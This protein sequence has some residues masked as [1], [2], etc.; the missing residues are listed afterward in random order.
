MAFGFLGDIVENIGEVLLPRGTRGATIGGAV[1][2]AIG[3]PGGAALGSSLGAATT[4]AISSG[5]RG[6]E[7]V[8]SP[9][10]ATAPALAPESQMSGARSTAM[11]PSFAQ[12]EG[13]VPITAGL[14]PAIAAGTKILRRPDVAATIGAVGGSVLDVTY[15]NLFGDACATKM[16][17]LVGMTKDGC[18][19]VTR[20]QQRVVILWDRL[21]IL[22][23][24]LFSTHG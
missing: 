9:T 2:G 17:K 18:P 13:R 16:P 3:G 1:G 19:T 24:I 12:Y 23:P 4:Q 21:R 11:A 20:K 15:S 14:G 5:Q 8:S 7:A 10:V 6:A 22:P